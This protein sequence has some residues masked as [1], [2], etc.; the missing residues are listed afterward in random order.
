MVVREV[1]YRLLNG[2]YGRRIAQMA[3]NGTN[4]QRIAH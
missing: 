1:Y 4:M 3:I 2:L